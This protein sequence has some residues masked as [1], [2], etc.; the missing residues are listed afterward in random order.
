M[1]TNHEEAHFTNLGTLFV[2]LPK[3]T[4]SILVRMAIDYPEVT[5]AITS[6]LVFKNIFSQVRHI[7]RRSV[8]KLS[9]MSTNP[10]WLVKCRI[11]NR[12]PLTWK[13][14]EVDDG[15]ST[16]SRVLAHAQNTGYCFHDPSLTLPESKLRRGTASANL[17]ASLSIVVNS[18]VRIVTEQ[19]SRI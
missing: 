7:C 11:S 10:S 5:L 2:S 18:T 4:E 3:N 8:A 1:F 16:V 19:Q 6:P 17:T 14:I 9:S 12:G 15:S 13:V